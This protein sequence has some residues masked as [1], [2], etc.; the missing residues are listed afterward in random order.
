MDQEK[1]ITINNNDCLLII[2][3]QPDFM[4]NGRLAVPGGF[5]IVKKVN[6]LLKK[7]NH[8]VAT[9]DWHPE[10]HLSFAINHENQA[11]GQ[12]IQM[13]YGSQMLW[14]AHCIQ[15]TYGASLHP[16]LNQNKI[17]LIIRK[18]FRKEI[19][20]YSAFLENDGKTNTGLDAWLKARMIKRVFVCG[21]TRPYCVDFSA[22]DSVQSGF[23][24]FIVEDA[25]SRLGSDQ[26]LDA[27]KRKLS[28]AGINFINSDQILTSEQALEKT[29]NTDYQQTGLSL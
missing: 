10:D 6:E 5:S 13:S 27:S 1:I 17:E 29:N 8:A 24:T 28:L 22:I 12:M 18:G 26:E 14:P 11:P 20:S 21:L 19:D 9:Q 15:G 23:E 3:L 2:D 16:D 4:E 7:Y 25:T